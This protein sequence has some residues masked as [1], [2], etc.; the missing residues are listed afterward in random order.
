[1]KRTMP[2]INIRAPWAELILSGEKT[3]ETRFYP[4][5]ERYVA[6]EMAIIETPG[7]DGDFKSRIVGVVI[8]GSS[9]EY[10][11]EAAFY[12]DTSR[13]LV[14]R[15]SPSFTWKTGSGKR[16]WGWPV[17]SVLR[18]SY[19]LPLNLRRGII[20]SKSVPVGLR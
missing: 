19:E 3:I 12:R 15:K 16:K 4:L 14:D 1:M 20:Y 6:K 8:F 18:V 10:K 9:F 13:H 7:P 11:S 5:P 2:G 17:L